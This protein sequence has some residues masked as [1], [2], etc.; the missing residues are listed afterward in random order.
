MAM[1]FIRGGQKTRADVL[2]SIISR[3]APDLGMCYRVNLD[4]TCP[5]G[6][7]V[8]G[9]LFEERGSLYLVCP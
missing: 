1:V 2:M 7:V 6:L 4:L 9:D 8:G 5:F 3:S